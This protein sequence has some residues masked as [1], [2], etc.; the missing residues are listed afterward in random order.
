MFGNSVNIH[1]F[2]AF[3]K[4][5]DIRIIHMFVW[6]NTAACM[7]VVMS[8]CVCLCMCICSHVNYYYIPQ[9]SRFRPEYCHW[10]VASVCCIC[11]PWIF[12]LVFFSFLFFCAFNYA[13]DSHKSQ[14]W[15]HR[16]HKRQLFLCFW[17]AKNMLSCCHSFSQLFIH[18]AAEIN[19][20]FAFGSC[21][22]LIDVC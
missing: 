21:L 1:F 4:N 7:Y 3:A 9:K 6:V 2:R 11:A 15:H 12:P 13:L 16:G 22:V 19:W 10:N 18:Q 14:K 8:V 20:I 17:Y 5:I